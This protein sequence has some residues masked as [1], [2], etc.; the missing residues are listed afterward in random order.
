MVPGKRI[1]PLSGSKARWACRAAICDNKR[2]DSPGWRARVAT[3]AGIKRT[4]PWIEAQVKKTRAG[5]S[6]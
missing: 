5:E 2:I 3:L 6:A 4:Y 1:N